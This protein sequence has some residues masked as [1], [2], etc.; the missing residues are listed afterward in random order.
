MCK[1]WFLVRRDHPRGTLYEKPPFG[2]RPY[3]SFGTIGSQPLGGELTL[4]SSSSPVK[5]NFPGWGGGLAIEI[6]VITITFL[7]NNE[8]FLFVYFCDLLLLF[9]A[10]TAQ[11]ASALFATSSPVSPIKAL[12]FLG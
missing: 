4:S 8:I 1:R 2:T 5:V 11:S 3:W 9:A 12:G 10:D 6:A 7:K